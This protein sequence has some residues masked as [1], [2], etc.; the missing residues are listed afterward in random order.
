MLSLEPLASDVM[1]LFKKEEYEPCSKKPQLTS[2]S[3][4]FEKD[5]VHV[6]YEEHLRNKYY[7]AGHN[8]IECC[9]QEITRSGTNA[10]ADDKYSW[11]ELNSVENS[12]RICDTFFR[13]SHTLNLASP[14][15]HL[16]SKPLSFP[17]QLNSFSFSAR[18]SIRTTLSG[19]RRKPSTR[20][21]TPS[22]DESNKC[23][24]FSKALKLYIRTASGHWVYSW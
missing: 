2:I 5:I 13:F 19:K 20:M 17:L 3:Q 15:A 14:S 7:A 1:K 8:Q 18:V 10:T 21:H 24:T 9:Y 12:I 6:V 11:V 4:D 23:R 22:F 16:S